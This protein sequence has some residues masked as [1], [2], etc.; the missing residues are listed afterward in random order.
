MPYFSLIPIGLVDEDVAPLHRS[1]IVSSRGRVAQVPPRNPW[2]SLPAPPHLAPQRTPHRRSAR[3]G[4]IP[5]SAVRVR[6]A[7]SLGG[8]GGGG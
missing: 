8:S 7:W 4:I 6:Y 3:R 1:S 2:V 5:V